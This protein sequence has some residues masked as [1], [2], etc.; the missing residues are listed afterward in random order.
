LLADEAGD[1]AGLNA[2]IVSLAQPTSA[3]QRA[4]LAEL[5]ARRELRRRDFKAAIAEAERSADLRR[6]SLDYRGMARALAVAADAEAGAGNAKAAAALFM[7]AGQSA[8][9]QGDAEMAR[10]WLRR[11]AAVGD[12]IVIREAARKAIAALEKPQSTLSKQ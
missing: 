9:A 2:A 5:L 3:D 1:A 7:R 8:A 4:D 10:S 11:A 6:I 12:D